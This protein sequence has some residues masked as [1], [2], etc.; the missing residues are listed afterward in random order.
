[1]T[2]IGFADRIVTWMFFDATKAEEAEII[3]TLLFWGGVI[4]A[5]ITAWRI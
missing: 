1:M 4:L 3:T 5:S 2:R